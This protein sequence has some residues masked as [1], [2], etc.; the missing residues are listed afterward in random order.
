MS[1]I[2]LGQILDL[3]DKDRTSEEFVKLMNGDDGEAEA[4]AKVCSCIW[5]GIEH[6]KVNSLQANMDH[7]EIWLEREEQN[8]NTRQD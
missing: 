1:E 4:C 3:I 7:I 8:D 6:R 2:T 5:K